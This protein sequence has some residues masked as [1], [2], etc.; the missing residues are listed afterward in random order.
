MYVCI[1]VFTYGTAEWAANILCKEILK[2]CLMI[3]CL[4]LCVTWVELNLKKKIYIYIYTFSLY[5]L[6]HVKWKKEFFS[7]E[8][9]LNAFCPKTNNASQWWPTVQLAVPLQKLCDCVHV[10]DCWYSI[11]WLWLQY[12]AALHSVLLVLTECLQ[13]YM[14]YHVNAQQSILLHTVRYQN[15][16]TYPTLNK[17][18]H[19]QQ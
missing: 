4:R 2:K 15:K 1:Y 12:T 6:W 16:E 5:T 3:W 18:S 14:Q 9:A 19:N 11:H 17:L 8:L 13:M 10:Q 7:T